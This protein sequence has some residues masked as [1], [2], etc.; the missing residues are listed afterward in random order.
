MSNFKNKEYFLQKSKSHLTKI[1]SDCNKLYLFLF[2][3][4]LI[5][6]PNFFKE[7]YFSSKN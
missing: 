4:T 6:A 5:K 2:K 7:K 3:K 1:P